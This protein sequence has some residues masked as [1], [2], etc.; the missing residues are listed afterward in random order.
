MGQNEGK[1][2]AEK[3]DGR[4]GLGQCLLCSMV[5][6]PPQQDQGTGYQTAEGY[7]RS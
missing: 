4:R 6:L 3:S 2:P 5:V 7:F 1:S